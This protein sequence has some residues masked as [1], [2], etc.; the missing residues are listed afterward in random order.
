[1]AVFQGHRGVAQDID[2]ETRRLVML[3]PHGAII[4]SLDG[5]RMRLLRNRGQRRSID[6]ESICERNLPNPPTHVLSE[7]QPGRSF[8][9]SG[10]MRSAYSGVDTH[11]HREDVF[12]RGALDQAL[13]EA[14]EGGELILI[15]PAHVVAVLRGHLERQNRKPAVREIVKDLAAL[16]PHALSARLRDHG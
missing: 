4:L 8:Q 7:P 10:P 6:L 9:S 13:A 1:V 15:A 14:G 16:T 5:G 12:C 11:Q 2:L 3:V